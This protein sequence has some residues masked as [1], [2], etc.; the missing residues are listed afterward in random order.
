LDLASCGA[1][2]KHSL[3]GRG[4]LFAFGCFP[5]CLLARRRLSSGLFARLALGAGL[6]GLAA[7]RTGLAFGVGLLRASHLLLFVA[8]PSGILTNAASSAVP[9][10]LELD[11][12]LAIRRRCDRGDLRQ[13][14]R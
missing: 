7:G 5:C 11:G 13:S 10:R 6:H 8:P 4:G 3:E 9:T 12:G 2:T 14:V 1:T